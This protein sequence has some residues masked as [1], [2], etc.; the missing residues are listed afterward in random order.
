MANSK[1]KTTT[2]FINVISN[3]RRKK[4]RL[5][6]GAGKCVNTLG[7]DSPSLKLCYLSLWLSLFQWK[8]L[9]V[10]KTVIVELGESWPWDAFKLAKDI[11][12][13]KLPKKIISISVEIED[14]YLAE[15]FANS[16]SNVGRLF[17]PHLWCIF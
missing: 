1:V 4:V 2:K 10:K 15:C 6:H 13:E 14:E 11:N 12:L 8:T 9:L 3:D 16:F 7:Q 5:K 17:W